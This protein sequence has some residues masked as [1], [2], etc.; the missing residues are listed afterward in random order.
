[1]FQ[2]LNG[3]LYDQC[4]GGKYALVMVTHDKFIIYNSSLN[5]LIL[6]LICN[7]KT[8]KQE[9]VSQRF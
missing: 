2:F 5:N 6:I 9:F 1:M 4:N 8:K 7:M 3:P